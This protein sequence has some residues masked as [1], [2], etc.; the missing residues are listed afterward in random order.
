MSRNRRYTRTSERARECVKENPSYDIG[1]VTTAVVFKNYLLTC[2]LAI[3]DKGQQSEVALIDP[4]N[5]W[6]HFVDIRYSRVL[7]IVRSTDVI[8]V[9]LE[10][11]AEPSDHG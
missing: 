2:Y 5:A 7:R 4:A 1:R 8:G 10:P 3:L 6:S 11:S 9:L